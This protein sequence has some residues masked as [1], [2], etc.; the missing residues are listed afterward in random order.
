MG[1]LDGKVAVVTGAGGGLGR[2]HALSLAGEGAKVLVNDLGG[3]RDGTGSGTSMADAV[4]REIRAAG[5]EAAA[6]YDNVA[7]LAGAQAI[8]QTAV[9]TFG[10]VDVVVNNAGILRDKTLLKM[11]EDMWDAVIAVHLK[12]TFAVTQ[13]A[14]RRMVEQAQGGRIINT[15]SLAGLIGNFG[16][17]NY[18]AAKAGI[19]G[20]TRVAAIELAKHRITVNAIVPLAK[21]RM[22][23]D[24]GGVPD[25]L[26]PEKVSPLVVF[27][28]SDLA[29][30]IS[31]RVFSI[32][33]RE[34]REYKYQVTD[35][36]TAKGSIW[37]PKE[38]AERF[39]EITR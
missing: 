34:I 4:V 36:A 24:L 14:A 26:G 27:L 20:F 22:T 15:S 1:L 2:C 35:G 7:T 13:A 28:A 12:G 18:G 23:A 32:Q 30:G 25:A 19:A 8:V 16:Q 5:G 11:E 21:T 3:A 9:T 31:G 10:R 17:S 38:I 6:N 37:T 33:N 39:D 29:K